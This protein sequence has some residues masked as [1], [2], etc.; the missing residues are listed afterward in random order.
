MVLPE[1]KIIPVIGLPDCAIALLT[2]VVISLQCYLCEWNSLDSDQTG[3][4]NPF[5]PTETG[6]MKIECPDSWNCTV[7]FVFRPRG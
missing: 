2:D 3:C 7:R 1:G 4:V 5:N 6:I